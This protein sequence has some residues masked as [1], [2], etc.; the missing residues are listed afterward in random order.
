MEHWH[1]SVSLYLWVAPH[2]LLAVVAAMLY[3]RRLHRAFPF[4]FTYTVFETCQFL[5]LFSIGMF[6]NSL[7]YQYVF[8]LGL[9]ISAIIR[10]GVVQEIFNCVFHDYP[11]LESVATFSM[12]CL[13]VVLILAS[14]AASVYASGTVSEDLIAGV[15]LLDRSV[16]MVQ[17]GLLLFIFVFSWIFGLSW[18]LFPLGVALGFGILASSDLAVWALRLLNSGMP[19]VSVLNLLLT[20]TFH[21]TVLVWLG[22][23]LKAENPVAATAHSMV[24]ISRWT[25][26]LERPLQ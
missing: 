1:R 3:L 6:S 13:I 14:I 23:L 9:A 15:A 12:R 5:A 19:F 26:E 25:G 16:A 21:V 8:G 10:F 20:G 2:I 11:R 22:Y 4:F 17:A 18:R 24:E 7:I